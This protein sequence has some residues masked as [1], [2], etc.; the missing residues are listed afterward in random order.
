[1]KKTFSS[2][3]LCLMLLT[4][5]ACG[6]LLGSKVIKKEIDT[7]RFR[8]D[9]ELEIDAFKHILH[10]NISSQL[11][12]LG[13]N[14]NLFIKVVKNDVKPGYMNR[15][16]F[17]AYL[18]KHETGITPEILKALK[19]VYDLNFLLRGEDREY[20]S[21]QNVD[22]VIAL[23]IVFN[24][25]MALNFGPIFES[26]QESTYT[27]HKIHKAR[28]REAANKIM[29]ALLKVFRERGGRIDTL[30]IPELLKA[31]TTTDTEDVIKKINQ[32]LFVKKVLLG[33]NKTVITH[34]ELQRFMYSFPYLAEIAL[35][36][37]RY[38]YILL[39]QESL[40]A[41][42]KLDLEHLKGII[43]NPRLGNRDGEHFV[44]MTDLFSTIKLFVDKETFD[45][46]KFK[47][48]VTYVKKIVMGGGKDDISGG[49]FKNLIYHGEN[50][51]QTGFVFHKMYDLYRVQLES[52]L[53][54]SINYDQAI[55]AIQEPEY[56]ND[57]KKFIR[58][59]KNYRFMKGEFESGFYTR[60]W[61]RNPDAVF[62]L[63]LY[64]YLLDLVMKFV[65]PDE[66]HPETKQP[67]AWG[68]KF[69]YSGTT[70][71]HAIDQFQLQKILNRVKKELIS[72]DLIMPHRAISTADTISLLGTLFQYQSDENIN[73]E[74]K[75]GLPILDVN[76]A[77]EFAVSLIS[78]IDMA[79]EMMVRFNKACDAEMDDYERISPSCFKKNFLK[80]MCE[81]YGD[82]YPLLFD[83]LGATEQ[84]D[85]VTGVKKR[86]C[87][88][89]NTDYNK[90]YLEMT[91]KASRT[92]TF[93]EDE[94]TGKPTEEIYYNEGDLMSILVEM[95]HV[96]ATFLRWDKNKNNNLDINEVDDAYRIYSWALD[97]FL[98]DKPSYI[99]LFKK[100]IYQF[101]I[102]FEEIPNEKDPKSIAKFLKFLV[103]LKKKSSATRKTFSSVLYGVSEENKKLRIA[104]GTETF[105]CNWLKNPNDIPAEEDRLPVT[106]PAPEM[107][108]SP[109]LNL[110]DVDGNPESDNAKFKVNKGCVHHKGEKLCIEDD[111]EPEDEGNILS[112]PLQKVCLILPNAFFCD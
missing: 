93:Y 90:A 20:I 71:T 15:E 27:L 2:L 100:Q 73:P 91:I 59:T 5:T 81:D 4:L 18:R 105:K 29:I 111:V 80:F 57:V 35:D 40:I 85:P 60:E 82:Y 66:L 34:V 68:T 107:S 38:K 26:K 19:A 53:P 110:V 101:M 49:D 28:V 102:K 63:A 50:I 109:L 56:R 62:E 55:Q 46:D 83:S 21:Q 92:C 10:Q 77:T 24:E 43:F 112:K 39:E 7:T 84:K 75:K 106:K 108:Y 32:V 104:N 87:E 16:M 89:P 48:L 17:E 30:D 37:T 98:V 36:A 67:V 12:C 25:Q 72:L 47:S 33:G 76:E 78:G 58:V 96:E 42:L 41:L 14:L 22:D 70:F 45:I 3:I 8:A 97:G 54:V 99:K 52:K 61:R 11:K 69:P 103:S 13:A 1:M 31:F 74:T 23:A 95:M 6:D 51:L 44:S 86:N 79:K 65:D 9:C 88:I 64:E 94:V